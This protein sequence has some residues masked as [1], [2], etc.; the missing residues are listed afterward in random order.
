MLLVGSTHLIC[1]PHSEPLWHPLHIVTSCSPPQILRHLLERSRRKAGL[2]RCHARRHSFDLELTSLD[3]GGDVKVAILAQRFI[4]GL[5]E[6]G[7]G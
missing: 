7:P 6:D 2:G 1:R 4:G 3:K 5:G